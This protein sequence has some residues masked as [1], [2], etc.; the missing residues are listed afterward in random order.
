MVA[1]DLLVVFPAQ[2]N[3]AAPRRLNAH[4]SVCGGR[5]Q[6]NCRLLHGFGISLRLGMVARGVSAGREGLST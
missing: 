2:T 6:P 5:L 3:P 4:A 1:Q